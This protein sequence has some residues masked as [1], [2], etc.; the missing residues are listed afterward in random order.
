MTEGPI[1]YWVRF[2]FRFGDG[3]TDQRD[4]GPVND[5]AAAHR[6]Y[7]EYVKDPNLINVRLLRREYT[8]IEQE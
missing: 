1:E 4:F 2:D 7:D 3:T 6:T 5:E 8:V